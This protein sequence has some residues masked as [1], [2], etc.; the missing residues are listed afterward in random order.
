MYP[1]PDRYLM[2]RDDVGAR[3]L[4]LVDRAYGSASRRLLRARGLQ[5]GDR[6][7]ELGCGTGQMTAWLGERVGEA[8]RVVGIDRS[9]EQLGYARR[10][11]QPWVEL[12]SGDATDTGLARHSFDWVYARLLLMHLPEPERV[13][14]HAFELLRPGGTLVC[15]ELV[16]SSSFC[17]PEQPAQAELHRMA[18]TMARTRACDFDIGRRLHSLLRAAGFEAVDATAHQP[19]AASGESK[20]IE[21]LSFREA[22]RALSDADMDDAT[23][24]CDALEAAADDPRVVY[25]QSRMVQAWGRKPN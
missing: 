16:I 4:R 21:Q 24:I 17:Y 2:R 3:R 20:H 6:V 19:T 22:L 11:C 7:V 12:R 13:V 14:A 25:G 10:R 18:L 23:K 15:E 8:G 1:Q 5:L 9:A